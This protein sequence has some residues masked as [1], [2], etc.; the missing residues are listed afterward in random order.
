M[1]YNLINLAAFKELPKVI[2]RLHIVYEKYE[3]FNV[4]SIEI[5]VDLTI[6]MFNATADVIL[7]DG[8]FIGVGYYVCRRAIKGGITRDKLLDFILVAEAVRIKIE[9][10]NHDLLQ[11]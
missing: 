2:R 6:M 4:A 11:D 8:E 3:Y 10:D 7:P 9:R 5:I 1:N